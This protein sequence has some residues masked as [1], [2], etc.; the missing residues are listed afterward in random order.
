MGLT[1]H[2]CIA[3]ISKYVHLA[4]KVPRRFLKPAVCEYP[5]TVNKSE[6]YM[7][8]QKPYFLMRHLVRGNCV[9]NGRD[10]MPITPECVHQ[11]LHF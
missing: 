4:Q 8:L 11:K 7:L 5:T 10:R 1:L 2:V 9:R 6:I 3:C